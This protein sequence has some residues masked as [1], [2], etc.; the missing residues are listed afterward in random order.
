LSPAFG[1]AMRRLR[2]MVRCWLVSGPIRRMAPAAKLDAA[3]IG[4][5]L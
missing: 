4:I 3:S 1:I 2:I 5:A